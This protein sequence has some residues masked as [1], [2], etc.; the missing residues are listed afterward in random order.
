ME[1]K[2]TCLSIDTN[3][4]APIF[5]F[6]EVLNTYLYINKWLNFQELQTE[7]YN[8]LLSRKILSFPDN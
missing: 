1:I 4:T 7:T 8:A 6:H 5:N 3:F 2:A